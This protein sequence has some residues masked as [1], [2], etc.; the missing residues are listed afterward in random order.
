MIAVLATFKV[1]EVRPM[2][3]FGLEE[4]GSI[5]EMHVEFAKGAGL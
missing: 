3:D 1:T 2:I 5:R 4:G